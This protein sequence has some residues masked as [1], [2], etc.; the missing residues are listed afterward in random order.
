MKD[1]KPPCTSEGC[2]FVPGVDAE[3]MFCEN[4]AQTLLEAGASGVFEATPCPFEVANIII[5]DRDQKFAE[6]QQ[7]LGIIGIKDY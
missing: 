7:K 2:D 3:N 1:Y 4:L 6:L 5:Q